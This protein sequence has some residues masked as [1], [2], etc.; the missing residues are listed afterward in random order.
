MLRTLG[1][2]VV[3]MSMALETIA[4]R[5]GGADVLG[6]ALVT[7]LAA[8]ESSPVSLSDVAAAGRA[9]APAVASLVRGVVRSLP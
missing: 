6:L 8:S 4:A 3:G 2:D 1:A 7:N 5:A 9:A